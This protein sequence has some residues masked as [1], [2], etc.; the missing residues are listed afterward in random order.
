MSR[1]I[2]NLGAG[3]HVAVARV[4]LLSA[5]VSLVAA[6]SGS[7]QYPYDVAGGPPGSDGGGAGNG[8]SGPNVGGSG[9]TSNGASGSSPSKSGTGAS[10]TAV[11]GSTLGAGGASAGAGGPAPRSFNCNPAA[12]PP[13]ATLRRLTMAQ[14][15]NTVLDLVAW[16]T[17]NEAAAATAIRGALDA[18]PDDRREAVPED[19]HG[20][21]RR[22]DQTLQQ[23]HVDSIY[24]LSTTVGAALTTSQRLSKVVGSCATDKDASNDTN[25]RDS[26]IENF[27]ARALRRPLSDAELTFYR[28]V[29]GSASAPD[30]AAYADVIAVFLNAPDFAYFVEH[31]DKEVPDQPG[32]YELTAYE[33]ASRLSY[34]LWQTAPD[35]ELLSAAADGSLLT[36]DGYGAEVERLISD[37]KARAALDEFFQDWAKV[38]DLPALDAK[39]ADPI[40]KAFAGS[41]LPQPTLRAAMIDDVVGMLD[42]YT[43]T[44][45]SGLSALLTSDKSFAR[46]PALARI[47]GTT[48]WNGT[49]APPSMPSG[50]RP[51]LFT[52]ALFL[53]TGSAN[54]RPIMKGVFLRRNVLCD[55]IPPPPPSSPS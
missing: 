46:D 13:E 18:L 10:G 22:L 45:P 32:V 36:S 49:A 28:S 14:Y 54:T 4:C 31:G 50:Q 41:E 19:L 47:Y 26:F 24:A 27:G 12:R 1:R 48:V 38:E 20:S 39:N 17:G 34:Q 40:F 37:A 52:R 33:L 15:R 16:A 35:D 25:C 9:A 53:S 21:Y 29:Y 2:T 3:T 5:A 55:P 7:E 8:A 23:A 43:W 51:G 42:Y 44:Q 6:C 30:P 11:G